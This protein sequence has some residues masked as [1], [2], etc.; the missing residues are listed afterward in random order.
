MFEKI[1]FATDLS[2]TYYR[3]IE[4]LPKTSGLNVKEIVL[5]HAIYPCG[6]SDIQAASIAEAK[7][8]LDEQAERLRATGV[9]VTPELT[10]GG[11]AQAILELADK[12][13]AS[14]IAIGSRRKGYRRGSLIGCTA[15]SVLHETI[16]PTLLI[17]IFTEQGGKETYTEPTECLS[18]IL[19]PTDFSETAEQAFLCVEALARMTGCAVTLYHV[20]DQ[21]HIDP[22][23]RDRLPEFDRVDRERME[24]M[25]A[26]LE[27]NSSGECR[28]EL[29]YG[30]PAQRILA[31]A[32]SGDYGLIIMGTQGRGFI[33]EIFMGNTANALARHAPMPVL[34][35]PHRR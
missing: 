19:Y 32:R 35:V 12:H 3:L 29:S 21:A 8:K 20:H 9:Q 7:G 2:S 31:M 22:Y 25:K 6:S 5:V 11:A 18:H 23:L 30:V 10:T 16:V 34:F 33:P 1:L 15:Y 4:C 27:L 17:P 28:V 14:M 13:N 26:H 24:R